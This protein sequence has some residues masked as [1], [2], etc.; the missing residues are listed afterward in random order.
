MLWTAFKN[1]VFHLLLHLHVRDVTSN[2]HA[3]ER[4]VNSLC[5]WLKAST[6]SQGRCLAGRSRVPC[7]LLD[8]R[9]SDLSCSGEKRA[10]VCFWK[11]LE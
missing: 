9:M 1:I 8:K 6:G 10:W 5:N 2:V 4:L 3:T 11:V 7:S